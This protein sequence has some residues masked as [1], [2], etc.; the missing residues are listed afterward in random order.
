MP[1]TDVDDACCFYWLSVITFTVRLFLLV[2]LTENEE[3][4]TAWV[5]LFPEIHLPKTKPKSLFSGIPQW[6]KK[7]NPTASA[8]KTLPPSVGSE[9]ACFDRL[10][11]LG[12]GGKN[13]NNNSAGAQQE[14]THGH[15][16]NSD[17]W[18]DFGIVEK[19]IWTYHLDIWDTLSLFTGWI[20]NVKWSFVPQT[21]CFSEYF[22][23]LPLPT[24]IALR[25]LWFK[26]MLTSN[27][28][29][30]L[31]CLLMANESWSVFT[32]NHMYFLELLI[33]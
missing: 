16:Y 20:S 25:G 30:W 1:L 11:A 7:C 23:F 17:T 26:R 2:S 33:W 15:S 9:S 22:S 8:L 18:L 6:I 28:K 21:S 29:L 12:L 5:F 4:T 3:H 10:S 19:H 32:C 24:W 31:D 27:S 13:N 14:N